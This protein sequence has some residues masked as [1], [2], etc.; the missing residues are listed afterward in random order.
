[1]TTRG[2]EEKGKKL[3]GSEGRNGDVAEEKKGKGNDGS[4]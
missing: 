3:G 4:N 2:E 1:M